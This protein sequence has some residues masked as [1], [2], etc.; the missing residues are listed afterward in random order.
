MQRVVIITGAS[1]GIGESLA[2][3][4]NKKFNENTLFLLIARD[5]AKLEKVKSDMESE[6]SPNI[7][8]SNKI[9]TLSHDFNKNINVAECTT[10]IK[11]L[12]KDEKLNFVTEL[13]VFYN[14]GTLKIATIEKVADEA[15]NE[16]QINVASIW[17]LMATVRQLFP[18]NLVP[19]QFH[20]N[21]S[22]L[23]ASKLQE[24]CSIYNA[25]RSARATMFKC[26][27]L[28][29]PFLRVFN[30]QPGPVYTDVHLLI[31]FL[32]FIRI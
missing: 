15:L 18:L 31:Y 17:V 26:L 7:A 25:T 3:L 8:F 1:K 4:T 32:F 6:K 30:Y 27:A 13:Y 29:Q 28:E 14:H 20:V 16:F 2:Y 11:S 24:S 19:T 12:I 23:W 10:L 9:I 21:I 5:L 22:S